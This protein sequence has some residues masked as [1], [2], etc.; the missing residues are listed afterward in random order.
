VVVF[1]LFS[2]LIIFGPTS[3]L[4]WQKDRVDFG[5]EVFPRT[6]RSWAWKFSGFLIHGFVITLIGEPYA[7]SLELVIPVYVMLLVLP[8]Y[9]LI[10]GERLSEKYPYRTM[11]YWSRV[12][13]VVVYSMMQIIFFSVA[14]GKMGSPVPLT[15]SSLWD[16]DQIGALGTAIVMLM[17]FRMQSAGSLSSS[18]RHR[19]AGFRLLSYPETGSDT[20]LTD[21]V[22]RE[23]EQC[24]G[25][26]RT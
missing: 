8:F 19:L 15:G 1:V 17:F 6:N 11:V 22:I 5:P 21:V 24:G 14:L 10:H 2:A 7:Y 9:S 23:T 13:R 4:L 26:G 18:I 16:F 20:E 25:C 12:V 3:R